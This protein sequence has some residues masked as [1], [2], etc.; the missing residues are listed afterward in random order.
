MAKI[1][2]KDKDMKTLRERG[3]VAKTFQ[4]GPWSL[5][6]A[7][8]TRIPRPKGRDFPNATSSVLPPCVPQ[9]NTT[10]PRVFPQKPASKIEQMDGTR[11]PTLVQRNYVGTLTPVKATCRG[12]HGKIKQWE[13]KVDVG[14]IFLDDRNNYCSSKIINNSTTLRK[15][16]FENPWTD[17]V[18]KELEKRGLDGHEIQAVVDEFQNVGDGIRDSDKGKW[19]MIVAPRLGRAG[20]V[21]QNDAETD[22]GSGDMDMRIIVREAQCVL[23]EPKPLRMLE[24]KRMILL[25]RE[26]VSV[27]GPTCRDRGMRYPMKA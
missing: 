8:G 24:M 1:G 9:S 16:I 12:I 23:E 22:E 18:G 6:K 15:S 26:K 3:V 21:A 11:I 10:K 13:S 17:D 5:S 27:G 14:E 7:T 25:C 19:K 4:S 2:S 20:L